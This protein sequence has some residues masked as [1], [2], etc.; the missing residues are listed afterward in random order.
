MLASLGIALDF[1]QDNQSISLPAGTV[2]GSRAFSS[3]P[4][5]LRHWLSARIISCSTAC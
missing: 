2:R 3:R 1:V 5:R 4:T